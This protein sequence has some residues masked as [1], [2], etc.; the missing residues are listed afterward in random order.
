MK[1]V[2]NNL[3]VNVGYEKFFKWT[4]LI[5]VT[6]SA[7][8]LIQLIGLLS[9][10]LIIRLLPTPEYAFYT[11]ANTMLGTM[12]LLAD[13]GIS[14]GVM[15][16]GAKVWQDRQKLGVVVNT[17]LILRRKF[18]IYSLIISLPILFYLLRHNGAGLIFSLLIIL[19]I[20]PAFYAALSDNL[21]EIASKLHQD[22]SRLQKNQIAT[23]LG[24]FFMIT[25]SLFLF[26]WTFIAILG[27][28][29]PRILANLRLKKIS[30]EYADPLQKADPIIKKEILSIVKRTLPGSIY[31]CISGQITVWLISIFGH[32]ESIAHIGALGRLAT[33]LT[34]FSTL[35]STLVVPRFARLAENK[36]L[37]INRFLLIQLGL[38]II[39]GMVVG[40]VYLFPTHLL[41]ILGK[42][43]EKL[44][45][46]I[47]LIAISSCL[48][49]ISGVTYS[50]LVAR[51]W[52]VKSV[53]YIP[54]NLA[55]Q[56]LLI[57][58]LDLSKIT[59]VLLFSIA[60]FSMGFCILIIYF[61]YCILRMKVKKDNHLNFT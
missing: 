49:M 39:S 38:F 32:T 58:V 20:I 36:I 5:A 16:H 23:G 13:G 10:I 18:A 57:L 19:S 44:T 45:N 55:F 17:G 27:N 26:P 56:L 52:V 51:G 53:V 29:I 50:A 54:I 12:T 22:I 46:E 48:A 4:K 33:L 34:V 61:I 21:L 3:S 2:A 35:F 37:L 6:T 7:Q 25:I 24:R 41:W 9:G 40:L 15:S 31:F 43:Y 28:G 8:A 30:A 60:D 1:R 14:A 11:L 42:G 47:F 59:S